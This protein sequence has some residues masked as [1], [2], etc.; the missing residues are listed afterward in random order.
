[1]CQTE[2]MVL[3]GRASHTAEL[4]AHRA[5]NEPSQVW[6]D[7]LGLVCRDTWDGPGTCL[8]HNFQGLL[9]SEQP[10]PRSSSSMFPPGMQKA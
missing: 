5:E 6:K 7:L 4:G 10:E 3:H 2:H 9:N 1:M 8:L